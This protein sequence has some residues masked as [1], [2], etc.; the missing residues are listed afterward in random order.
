MTAENKL[1]RHVVLFSWKN[2]AAPEKI[3][4]IEQAFA[5][6]P[7][8]I[9]SIHGFEWGTDISGGARTKGFTHCF[10]VTFLDEESL[11]VYAAH[12]EHKAFLEL[13]KPSMNDVLALDYWS[14]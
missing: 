13:M 14:E 4:E 11:A 10:V 3:R 9:D 12:P 6:L 2:D 5:E 7:S 8:K 1:L